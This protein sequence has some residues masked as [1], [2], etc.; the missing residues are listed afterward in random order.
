L[1]YLQRPRLH[2]FGQFETDVSTVN[3]TT[4]NYDAA[5]FV[6]GDAKRMSDKT[7]GSWN[8]A[9]TGSFRLVGC[10]VTSAWGRD[11]ERTDDPVIGMQ[12]A[13]S[14]DRVPAKLVDLDPD[15]QMVS[16][17]WGLRIRLVT[18]A[19]QVALSG[20]YDVAPFTDIWPRLQIQAIA[21]TGMSAFY[22]SQL[23]DVRWNREV[24]ANSDLLRELSAAANGRPLSI[25]FVVDHFDDDFTSDTFRLGRLCGSLGVAYEHEPKH[26]VRGRQLFSAEMK[27]GFPFGPHAGFGN[28]VAIV[29]RDAHTV[30]VD[31]GNMLPTRSPD[32]AIVPMTLQLGTN[33][34]SVFT[35]ISEKFTCDTDWYAH[36]AGVKEFRVHAERDLRNTPLA[37]RRT[38]TETPTVVA[39]EAP[40]GEHVRADG[41]VYRLD[42]GAFVNV[43]IYSTRFGEALP[44]AE[45]TCRFED[46]GT[47]APDDPPTGVP[48]QAL[49]WGRNRKNL[50][51]TTLTS[52]AD[53]I[54]RLRLCAD[55]P[56]NRRV[57]IDG[58]IYGI[59][60]LLGSQ[61]AGTA[62]IN[63]SDF[64]S[65]LVFDEIKI[66]KQPT[67]YVHVRPILQPYANLYPV[68][69]HVLDLDDY[70]SVVAHKQ[71]LRLAFLLPREDPNYM[72]VTRDLSGRKR[73]L[74]IKWL[75]GPGEPALGHEPPFGD[76]PRPAPQIDA[77][78]VPPAVE[79]P[80]DADLTADGSKAEF[81]RRTRRFGRKR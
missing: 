74:L 29:D 12:L 9:G 30:T 34:G 32:H 80:I 7:L 28:A 18:A 5:T 25:R 73:D 67:W 13:D 14:G 33:T 64:I 75:D 79:P 71:M 1:S 8:P 19:G 16:E 68:M 65:I 21:S 20:R 41:F 36:T 50:F 44:K 35:A 2:F 48:P 47:N 57:Y 27:P 76:V 60:P 53:G 39:Q 23:Y 6:A 31:F 61:A 62:P 59:R 49:R 45:I 52:G 63:P 51:P 78:A 38:D 54:A 70:E 37:I 22:Q 56:G 66:P 43:P 15:Q 69:R 42:P 72:P 81:L 17:I 4:S 24:C 40:T 11:G 26:F 55:A 58:Q 77:S 10:R 3:N 46:L